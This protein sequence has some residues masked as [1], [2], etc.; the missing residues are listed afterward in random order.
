MKLLEKINGVC[1]FTFTK[2]SLKLLTNGK[3]DK[4]SLPHNSF[5]GRPFV[6]FQEYILF[7]GGV[8]DPILVLNGNYEKIREIHNFSLYAHKKV[9][10]LESIYISEF[11]PGQ[12]SPSTYYRFDKDLNFQESVA[13]SNMSFWKIAK[14]C[15][16][17]LRFRSKILFKYNSINTSDISWRKD[18]S[19]YLDENESLNNYDISH[20]K[21]IFVFTKKKKLI[22]ISK[23][24]GEVQFV[25][26]FDNFNNCSFYVIPHGIIASDGANTYKITF[27]GKLVMTKPICIPF[28]EFNTVEGMIYY[29]NKGYRRDIRNKLIY[30]FDLETLEYT[31][32]FQLENRPINSDAQWK[33]NDNKLYILD[34]A[35]TLYIFNI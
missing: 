18:L 1:S 23:E 24:T 10:I 5:G 33:I 27:D 31:S 29:K 6:G 32:H 13:C 22:C 34:Q 3:I 11:L 30:E 7:Q 4:P 9:D 28:I 25:K 2:K 16:I 15:I 8:T 14:E 19:D 26:V 12:Y 21:L 20:D 35:N 17:N